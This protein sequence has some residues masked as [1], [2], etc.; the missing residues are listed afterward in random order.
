M[1]I[2]TNI[3]NIAHNTLKYITFQNKIEK[4]PSKPFGSLGSPV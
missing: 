3:H 2:N 4:N 1:Y